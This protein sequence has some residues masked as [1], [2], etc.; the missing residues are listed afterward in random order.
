[1]CKYTCAC[2][3]ACAYIHTYICIECPYVF[4]SLGVREFKREERL[5]VN[6]SE[7]AVCVIDI[8][9]N[10][11]AMNIIL[12]WTKARATLPQHFLSTWSQPSLSSHT[13][14]LMAS[15]GVSSFV[16]FFSSFDHFTFTNLCNWFRPQGT[17]ALI[18][19]HVINLFA[20][21]YSLGF[22]HSP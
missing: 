20:V 22:L 16:E 4:V 18:E 9:S 2:K 3:H 6:A 10:I 19:R 14:C 8:A 11:K 13:H 12:F 21:N 7:H 15:P 1:M 5:S 17:R